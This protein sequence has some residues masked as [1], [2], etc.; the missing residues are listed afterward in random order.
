[1]IRELIFAIKLKKAANEG[2][3]LILVF[4]QDGTASMIFPS[5]L[6]PSGVLE[7]YDPWKEKYERVIATHRFMLGRV[8][9]IP[10]ASGYPEALGYE[11]LGML[12]LA[13]DPIR[14]EIQNKVADIVTSLNDETFMALALAL[15]YDNQNIPTKSVIAG[16]CRESLLYSARIVGALKNIGIEIAEQVGLPPAIDKINEILD[17]DPERIDVAATSEALGTILEMAGKLEV[18][19]KKLNWKKILSLIAIIVL[20][21]LLLFF[22]PSLFQM[23]APAVRNLPGVVVP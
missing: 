6:L 5:C 21:T 13:H 14:R 19:K 10:V 1:M 18:Y 9:I 3:P 16:A 2:K 11:A 17:F 8:H 20:A 22:L 7:Y 23:F 12:A 4:R 15:G